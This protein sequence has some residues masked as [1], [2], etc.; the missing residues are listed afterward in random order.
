LFDYTEAESLLVCR[1]DALLPQEA[2]TRAEAMEAD[3]STP[4]AA[5]LENWQIRDDQLTYDA[6][7]KMNLPI[8]TVDASFSRRVVLR[9]ICRYTERTA[10]NVVTVWGVAVRLTV[11][12]WSAKLD[13]R[14]TL[15]M[16]AAQAQL[17]MVNTSADLRIL[18]F[19]NNE[20]G[21]L[22]PK[23]ETLDVGSY[24]EYTKASD[25]VVAFIS[26]RESNIVPVVL[27]TFEKPPPKK[28]RL[29]QAI[30]SARATRFIARR[31]PLR[32]ALDS[33]SAWPEL[34]DA[35]KATYAELVPDATME[36]RPTDAQ[37][38]EAHKW[39]TWLDG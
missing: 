37:A 10:G 18:G 21:K 32:E 36:T 16:V 29:T 9:D 34:G 20:V 31:K 28:E 13:G 11:T 27:K 2:V 15:P 24:G 33:T 23:F 3:P 26:K 38:D 14:L 22:L 4:A 39:W 5:D 35:V 17:G 12:V 8:A 1:P 6:A 19:K 7:L 30:G 25:A